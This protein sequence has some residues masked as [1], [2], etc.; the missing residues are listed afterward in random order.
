MFSHP[1][2]LAK[3]LSFRIITEDIEEYPVKHIIHTLGSL[4]GSSGG[5]LLFSP[6]D[7]PG[8]TSWPSAFL[9]Y[10]HGRAVGWQAIGDS[11][12]ASLNNCD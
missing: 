10:R 11:I 7:D 3:R 6:I 5:N 9:H 8:L 2:G 1:H 12:R 4:S